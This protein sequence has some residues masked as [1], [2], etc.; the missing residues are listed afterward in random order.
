MGT[1]RIEQVRSCSPCQL[2]RMNAAVSED[3]PSATPLWAL[4][5]KNMHLNESDTNF[6]TCARLLDQNE[7]RV[8]GPIRLKDGLFFGPPSVSVDYGFL[9]ANKVS[10]IVA[11]DEGSPRRIEQTRSCANSGKTN[12][13]PSRSLTLYWNIKEKSQ[14]PNIIEQRLVDMAAAVAFIEEA[15]ELGGSCLLHSSNCLATAATAAAAYFVVKPPLQLRADAMALLESAQKQRLLLQSLAG[16]ACL[17]ACRS[18]VKPS[19][20]CVT[21]ELNATL[22]PPA[23]P[24]NKF[25]RELGV[26]SYERFVLAIPNCAAAT[27]ATDAESLLLHNTLLNATLPNAS[28]ATTHTGALQASKN[29]KCQEGEADK[30]GV[31]LVVPARVL[32]QDRPESKPHVTAPVAILGALISQSPERETL[33]GDTTVKVLAKT[34]TLGLEEGCK[35]VRIEFTRETRANRE[36]TPQAVP[37]SNW[38]VDLIQILRLSFG[39]FA[40]HQAPGVGPPR[41]K[42]LPVLCQALQSFMRGCALPVQLLAPGACRDQAQE[43]FM[44]PR[45]CKSHTVDRNMSIQNQ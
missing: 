26:F 21:V 31:A 40:Y 7:N 30:T 2:V 24:Q 17:R 10:H 19:D 6:V 29:H 23:C 8:I 13:M 44:I 5:R 4:S 36:G 11:I 3:T 33:N 43:F 16:I 41:T 27:P 42:L 22:A 20:I 35:A 15:N 34:R 37:D 12:S 28:C 25:S 38:E 9:E 1:Q 45:Q 14:D 32:L 39:N 18:T